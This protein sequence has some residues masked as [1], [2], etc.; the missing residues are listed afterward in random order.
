MN[1]WAVLLSQ[2]LL[3]WLAIQ[4]LLIAIF[5]W[6]LRFHQGKLLPDD[7]LPKTAIVLCLRGA[8]PFLP[9]CLRALL[10]QNYP[11][12]DLK[13]IVDRQEDPAWKIANDTIQEL[14]ATN[15]QISPLWFIR[16]SCSLKCSS[17]VQAVSELDNSYQVV[18]LVDADTVVHPNWL[19]VW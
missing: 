11:H 4:V 10:N 7:K 15:V 18:A 12:Y 19:R 3:G 9:N 5:V 1:D 2:V 8:D 14:G 16:K 17:L 13:L 6:N